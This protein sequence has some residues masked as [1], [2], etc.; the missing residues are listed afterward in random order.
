MTA[1]PLDRVL[2]EIRSLADSE[3]GKGTYLENLAKQFLLNDSTQRQM[4]S[5]VWTW[6]EWP[7][8]P[9][10]FTKKDNGIDLVAQ[11]HDGAYTAVQVK[12]YAQDY[13]IQKGD[14]NS[15]LAESAREPFQYGLVIDTTE[16]EWSST[17]ESALAELKTVTQRIGLPDLRGS[18]IDWTHYSPKDPNQDIEFL[19]KKNLRQTPFNLRPVRMLAYK[20]PVWSCS[21]SLCP[22]CGSVD[23]TPKI[24]I[25]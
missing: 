10:H 2:E 7:D 14:L 3:R 12:F 23:T 24:A 4:F 16:G 5:D 25:A 13:R 19:P 15:F 20:T 6:S 17:A 11:R 9:A 22:P 8:R 1:H 21:R 18:D